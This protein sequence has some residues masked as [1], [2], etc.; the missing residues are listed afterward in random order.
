MQ[1]LVRGMQTLVR[2]MQ[3]LVRKRTPMS[4]TDRHA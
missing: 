3:T 1:T 2:G 4:E